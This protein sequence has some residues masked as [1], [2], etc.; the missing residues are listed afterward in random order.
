[1]QTHTHRLWKYY[2]CINKKKQNRSLEN[3]V[4]QNNR[5]NKNLFSIQHAILLTYLMKNKKRNSLFFS[6]IFYVT[7]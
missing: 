6:H 7:T 5:L 4:C 2:W 3:F 1:M